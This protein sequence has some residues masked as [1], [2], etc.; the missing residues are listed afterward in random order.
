MKKSVRQGRR[1]SGAINVWVSEEG[2]SID[3]VRELYEEMLV[4]TYGRETLSDKY[5]VRVVRIDF[6]RC[7]CGIKK[8]LIR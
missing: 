2:L 1:V 6:L 4:P 7:T 3:A 8:G 5:K